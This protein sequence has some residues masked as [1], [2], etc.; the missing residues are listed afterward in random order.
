MRPPIKVRRPTDAEQQTL[1]AGLR[2]ADATVLRRSQI[3]LA[4]ARG[5]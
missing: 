3:I 2:S 1:E 5:A 4:S